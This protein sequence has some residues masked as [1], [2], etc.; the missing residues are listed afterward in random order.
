MATLAN[1]T[2]QPSCDRLPGSLLDE[3]NQLNQEVERLRQASLE[4]EAQR[5]QLKAELKQATQLL[6]NADQ[7]AAIA[8]ERQIAGAVDRVRAGLRD[9]AGNLRAQIEQLTKTASEFDAERARLTAERDEATR[10]LADMAQ[11]A[12]LALECQVASEVTRVRG[13]LN[14]EINRLREEVREL[15]EASAEW[16]RQR[17]DFVAA[18]HLAEH[19]LVTA[20][21][22]HRRALAEAQ[23]S[24]D[25]LRA[26]MQQQLAQLVAETQKS[27][28]ADFGA[29]VEE[30]QQSVKRANP[31]PAAEFEPTMIIPGFLRAEVDRVQG[32]IQSITELINDD[33]TELSTVIRKNAERAELESYLRG[34]RFCIAGS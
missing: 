24:A 14:A 12:A 21:D 23:S 15:S 17:S 6:A 3:E 16:A 30:L 34:I 11:S 20:Q 2:L 26:E 10:Q 19:A 25:V 7:A 22:E 33:A 28:I 27:S 29:D 13:E 32:L 18:R 4:W 5:T 8:L 9:E 1:S 31:E